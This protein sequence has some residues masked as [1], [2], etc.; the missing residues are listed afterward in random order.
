MTKVLYVKFGLDKRVPLSKG[1]EIFAKKSQNAEFCG[2]GSELELSHLQ[3]LHDSEEH[4]PGM[5]EDFQSTPCATPLQ[6]CQ[7]HGALTC[8]EGSGGTLSC[9][10]FISW[11]SI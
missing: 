3:D 10:C 2:I 11:A 1:K 5:A 7:M 9:V 8:G 6:N 4:F